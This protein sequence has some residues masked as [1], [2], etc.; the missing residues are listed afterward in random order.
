[1]EEP[2][3]PDPIR[4]TGPRALAGEPPHPPAVTDA[5]Q[6]GRTAEEEEAG[7]GEEYPDE[8]SRP[9]DEERPPPPVDRAQDEEI[10]RERQKKDDKDQRRHSRADSGSAHPQLRLYG[11]RWQR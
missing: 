6:D 2:E 3:Q 9:R 8:I 11:T 4:R 1:H 5:R 7:R 10:D